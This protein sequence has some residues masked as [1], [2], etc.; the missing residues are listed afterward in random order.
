MSGLMPDGPGIHSKSCPGSI[1]DG[2]VLG[3]PP[4][5]TQSSC[6][7]ETSPMVLRGDSGAVVVRENER[8]RSLIS[9]RVDETER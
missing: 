4:C 3:V 1:S 2:P 7:H 6:Y 5:S 8:G 9:I